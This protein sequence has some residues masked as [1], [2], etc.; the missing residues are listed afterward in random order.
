MAWVACMDGKGVGGWHSWMEG[1][2]RGQEKESGLRLP[3]VCKDCGPE[4]S[5]NGL[6]HACR[7]C[8]N[9]YTY[10]V[11]SGQS[12]GLWCWRGRGHGLHGQ[13]RR[14]PR[15][16]SNGRGGDALQARMGSHTTQLLTSQ[17]WCLR[18]RTAL[19]HT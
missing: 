2:N 14:T 4:C 16:R 18:I 19:L 13:C 5:Q 1:M 8:H 7:C 3:C 9:C 11:G 15:G 17:A 6:Q 12:G 10:L